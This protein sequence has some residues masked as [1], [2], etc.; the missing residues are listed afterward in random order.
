MIALLVLSTISVVNRNGI[1]YPQR[2][3]EAFPIAE[4]SGAY[5]DLLEL[6]LQGTAALAEAS[7]TRPVFY[8]QP[9]HY[10]FSYPLMGYAPGPLPNGHSIEHEVP[11]REARLVD[12]PESFAMLYEIDWL[13][14]EEI[15]EVWDQALIDPARSVVVTTITAGEYASSLIE[16]TT[17]NSAS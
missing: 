17:R 5:R 3:N 13:G 7:R 1:L 10:R 11:Y 4:R 2:D 8:A 6:Q 12:F 14:G 9:E 16:I 15:R